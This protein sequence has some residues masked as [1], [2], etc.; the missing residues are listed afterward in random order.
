MVKTRR[1]PRPSPRAVDCAT[2]ETRSTSEWCVLDETG[3]GLLNE[4]KVALGF[5]P[6][7]SVFHQGNPCEGVY[8]IERGTLGIYKTDSNGRS[9]LLRLVH[10]GQTVGYSDYFGGRVH[11]VSAEA[12]TE[13]TVCFVHDAGMRRLM[14]HEPSLSMRFLRHTIEDLDLAK[15]FALQQAWMSVRERLA[16][17]LLSLRERY[18][19]MNAEGHLEI[20]LPLTRQDLADML[21]TRV[22]TVH[23]ALSALQRDGVLTLHGRTVTV[24][25][26]DDLLDE[27]QT[28]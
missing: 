7:E 24:R 22:E 12:L 18:G 6:H 15:T 5:L 4:V 26:L 17:L 1:T 19:Q 25:D 10:A 27:V 21:G 16:D 11:T 23:R 8:S 3:I 2:C 28:A 14:A 9:L 20:E 13:C